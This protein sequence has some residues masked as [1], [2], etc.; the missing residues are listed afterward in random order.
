MERPLTQIDWAAVDGAIDA[1]VPAALATLAELVA[2]ES[3][4]GNEAGS[5]RIVRRELERLDFEVEEVEIDPRMRRCRSR[6][7]HPERRL[8]GPARADRRAAPERRDARC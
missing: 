8:R 3:T 4:L 6:V 2:E 5:Q 7:G 1:G